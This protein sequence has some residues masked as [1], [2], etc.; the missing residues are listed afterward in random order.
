MPNYMT[1]KNGLAYSEAI[2]EAYAVAVEDEP[3][4][5]TLEF[6]HP[7]FLDENGNPTGARI[8]R[9]N[10]DLFAG[11]EADAP[12]NP[13][14]TVRFVALF[15][16]I[17]LPGE[18]NSGALPELSIAVANVGRELLQYLDLAVQS[19]DPVYITYRPYLGSDLTA[20]HMDPVLTMTMKS[21]NVD[22]TTINIRAGFGDL[23][24]RRFPG[25]DY[26]FKNFPGL[27]SK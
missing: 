9:D 2:A 21:V 20:P 27:T 25:M 22:L 6:R 7:S 1:P 16:D 12:V 5:H 24:N 23:P 18:G 13:L 3:V 26:T 11:L 10:K 4:F 15:F 8:V 19:R 14:M 17:T